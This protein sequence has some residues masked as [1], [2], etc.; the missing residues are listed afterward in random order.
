MVQ[1]VGA[2]PEVEPVWVFLVVHVHLRG[3]ADLPHVVLADD[4]AGGV[5]GATERGE[6]EGDERRDDGDDHEKLDERERDAIRFDKPAR[7]IG[8]GS[9]RSWWAWCPA[10]R[11]QSEGPPR[12]Y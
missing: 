3:Q 4:V 6:Q 10:G 11:R 1:T 9:T 5:A 7:V 12:M 2:V 8:N